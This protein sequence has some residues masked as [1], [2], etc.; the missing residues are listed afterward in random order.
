MDNKVVVFKLGTLKVLK[1]VDNTY[2]WS[3]AD[4]LDVSGPFP[5][6]Y[7]AVEGYTNILKI[8]KAMRQLANEVI[9]S[10]VLASPNSAP[11][12]EKPIV[13][14]LLINLINVDFIQRKRLG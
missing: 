6:I 5:S 11:I 13:E 1:A 2:F 7:Q 3:D 4:S 12:Q 8:R 9:E 10:G 14:P